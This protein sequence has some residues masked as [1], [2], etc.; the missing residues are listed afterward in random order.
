MEPARN[1]K[2]RGGN[3]FGGQRVGFRDSIYLMAGTLWVCDVGKGILDF[4]V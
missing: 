4:L 1:F 3:G 2:A